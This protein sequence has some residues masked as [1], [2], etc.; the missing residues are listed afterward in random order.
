MHGR[1]PWSRAKVAPLVTANAN[2]KGI[3]DIH[4]MA[5]QSHHPAEPPANMAKLD[6][7]MLRA[8]FPSWSV[9]GSPG[10]WFAV[11]GGFT[12]H[13]GP[14]SLLRCHLNATSL[15]A[16]AEKLCLQEY[17]DGLSD[18]EL[19]DAWQWA[20]LPHPSGQAAS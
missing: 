9:G 1:K 17:L 10:Y 14:R 7:D 8:T 16:L 11:R 2:E 4:I 13:D 3:W 6:L 18:D 5:D 20:D 12:A 19:E 15:L